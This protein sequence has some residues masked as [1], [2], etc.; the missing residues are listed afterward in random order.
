ME[1]FPL[2]LIETGER[3]QVHENRKVKIQIHG[4]TKKLI[5]KLD[6]KKRKAFKNIYCGSKFAHNPRFGIEMFNDW[7]RRIVRYIVRG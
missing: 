7:P 1:I 5:Q 6:G 4:N 2:F 3:N